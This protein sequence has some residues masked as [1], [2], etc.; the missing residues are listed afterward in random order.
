MQTQRTNCHKHAANVAFVSRAAEHFFAPAVYSGGLFTGF[1]SLHV[2]RE[3]GGPPTAP[4][5]WAGVE[6]GLPGAGTPAVNHDDTERGIAAA[7]GTAA[8]RGSAEGDRA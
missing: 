7:R 6:T 4:P 5:G 2:A 1:N 3:P 8:D